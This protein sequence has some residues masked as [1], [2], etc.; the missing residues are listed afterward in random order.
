MAKYFY[1]SPKNQ[2]QLESTIMSD[3]NRNP[4]DKSKLQLMCRTRWVERHAAFETHLQLYADVS[5]Y[6]YLFLSNLNKAES[7]RMNYDQTHSS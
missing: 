5:V 1:N 4:K 2:E 3:Q 7:Y 6:E